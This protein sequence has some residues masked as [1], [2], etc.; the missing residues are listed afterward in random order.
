M[1]MEPAETQLT[2]ARVPLEEA[3]EAFTLR[4][5]SGR[6]PIVVL[7][8]RAGR[9]NLQLLLAAGV[10]L[11]VAVVVWLFFDRFDLFLLAAVVAVVLA[12]FGLRQAFLVPV[13]EGTN[14]LLAQR[15]RFLR[16]IGPGVHR[17]P[18]YIAVSHLVTRREIPFDVPMTEAATED[19]VRAT[20][21]SLV[22]FAIADPF[23]FVYNISADDFDH[24][25]QAICQEALRAMVRRLPSS[26]VSD[27]HGQDKG[28]LRAAIGAVVAPYGVEV[29]ATVTTYAQPPAEFLQS[30][31]ARQLAVLQ[32]AEQAERQA[33]AQ[34]RQADAEALARQEALARVAREQ[35]TLQ[36]EVQRAEARR[37]LAEAEAAVEELRL[38][39]LEERLRRFPQASQWEWEGARLEVARALAGN[40]R[41][42]LQVGNADQ[43]AH[44]LVVRDVLA[45][46]APRPSPTA[47]TTED[48]ASGSPP[49]PPG[50]LAPPRE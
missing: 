11:A 5:A 45:E 20:V 4:D 29:R 39:R 38:A 34:R 37:H 8:V 42:V 1:A 24:V 14:A 27:L 47:Q 30:Q 28:E 21:D 18:P 49:P 46:G 6:I 33:L 15:G 10:A 2:Q 7:P 40:T 43:I 9:V 32:R 22:T 13:P 23:R 16:T 3:A 12:V 17:I 36:A 44:A 50:P 19:N 25:F 41:A 31:E 35:D 26:Q 48:G